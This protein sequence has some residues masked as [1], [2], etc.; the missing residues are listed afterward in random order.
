MGSGRNLAPARG[1]RGAPTLAWL[2]NPCRTRGGKGERPPES[3]PFVS[4]WISARQVNRGAVET[5]Y[6]PGACV[7]E[8][9][10]NHV[11]RIKRA[12]AQ[13]SKSWRTLNGLPRIRHAVPA[14]S[15]GS[16]GAGGAAFQSCCFAG[17]QP[18]GRPMRPQR[19]SSSWP[20]PPRDACGSLLVARKNPAAPSIPAQRQ[21]RGLSGRNLVRVG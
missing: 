17:V 16:P 8:N 1:S 20:S 5:P 15:G 4:E 21:G 3:Q 2:R 13:R 6:G 14:R 19:P 18:A 7:K 11:F 10:S 12:T 9:A